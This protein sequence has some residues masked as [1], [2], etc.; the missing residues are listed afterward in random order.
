VIAEPVAVAFK[1]P[2]PPAWRKSQPARPRASA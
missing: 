2:S 1:K